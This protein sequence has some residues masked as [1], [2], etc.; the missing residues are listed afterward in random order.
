MGGILDRRRRYASPIEAELQLQDILRA[1]RR[2][3]H[4]DLKRLSEQMSGVANRKDIE[5]YHQARYGLLAAL[6][7]WAQVSLASVATE[8]V[9]RL[10]LEGLA[11]S[12]LGEEQ[13]RDLAVGMA[14]AIHRRDIAAETRLME[15]VARAYEYR[16]RH[17]DPG[18]WGYYAGLLEGAH[19][20]LT[21]T[22]QEDAK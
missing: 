11:N 14:V 19:Q 15:A 5:P 6:T 20:I 22:H 9:L 18:A 12:V 4:R 13:V 17:Q 2:N 21:W 8:V 3:S 10:A 16:H 1:L 7:G